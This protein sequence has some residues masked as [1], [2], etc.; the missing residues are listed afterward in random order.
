MDLILFFRSS[1]PS[2]LSFYPSAMLKA[3][4]LLDYRLLAF[5][6]SFI[7]FFALPS[8]SFLFSQENLFD[9][10]VLTPEDGLA[11]LLTTSIYKD[12]QGFMWAGTAYGLNRYDGYNFKLF[13]KEKNALAANADIS[14][15][16][17]DEKGR[18]WLFYRSGLRMLPV[19]QSI[20]A[21]DIFDPRSQRAVPFDSLFSGRAP[22][23]AS[24]I[25][26]PKIIDPKHRLWIHTN[27]GA[28]FLYENGEFK[29]VFQQDGA[30]FQFI[31]ID[32]DE[33][34]WLGGQNHLLHIDSSGNFLERLEL[35][36]QIYGVWTGEG[37]SMWL[38]TIDNNAEQVHI[39]I[40]SQSQNGH[41]TPL[42]FTRNGQAVEI[43]AYKPF[44]HLSQKRYWLALVGE[45][46]HV[47]NIQGRWLY[48]Y[49]PI[50]GRRPD[51]EPFTFFEDLDRLWLASSTGILNISAI[52]NPFQ[53]IHKKNNMFT[54]CRSIT[55]DENGNI[56][57]LNS[58]I[59]QWNVQNQKSRELP[60]SKGAAYCLIYE[61]SMVWAGI[62]NSS[63]IAFQL[64]LRTNE[65][66][67]YYSFKHENL[68]IYT[69]TKTE[70]PGRY[71]A[72]LSKGIAYLDIRKKKLLP[73]NGYDLGDNENRLLEQ[74]EVNFIHKNR[75]GYWLATNNGIF[76]LQE[77]KG[78]IQHFDKSKDD[79]PF[80]YI[81]HI[82]EDEEGFFWLATKGGGVIQ[83]HHGLLEEAEP[84]GKA[85][86]NSYRQ[87]TTEDGLANNFTYA[88]YEDDFGKLWIPS[89]K[90]L[91][92]VDKE[93]F[94]VRT[95]T[96]DDGL[97]HNEFNFTSH[98]QS[99]D[100]TL[101]F[102]GLDG[103]ISFHPKTFANKNAN[104]T[105]MAIIGYFVL[106]EGT[107]KMVDK[108][109]LLQEGN[110]LTIH[111]NDKFIELYFT[112]LDFDD[113][114]KHQYAYQ[115]GGYSSS[116]HYPNENFIRITNLPYGKYTL[117]IKGQNSSH[118]WSQ[119]E[120]M[121]AIHVV[122]PFYLQ[123]WFITLLCF[124]GG[125]SML[126]AVLLRIKK[127]ESGKKILEA[128]V[129]KRTRQLEEKT[130]Q[131]ET[132]N[133]QIAADKQVI[134]AQAESLQA[135]DKAKT[136]FFSNITHEFRTPLTL[137]IGPLEQVI[138][139]QS[140]PTIFRRR[141]HG[142]LGNARHLL[143]LINQLLDISKIESGQMQIEAT[144]GDLVA[145]T[146][147][148]VK[149]F[150]PLA[151][152]KDLRLSFVTHMN[153]W[154]TQFDKEK[155]D[156]IVYN[157]LSNAIKFT[158][159]ANAIQV[160]LVNK[161]HNGSEFIQLDVKDTGMGIEKKQIGY[162]FDR[163]YQTDS[164][165]THTQG[166]TGIGLA[167]VKELVEMQGGEVR[168][169]SELGKGTT[170]EVL[171][172]VLA[173]PH[174]AE[175]LIR[176]NLEISSLAVS[177]L[178]EKKE[179]TSWPPVAPSRK[180]KLELLIIEDNDE[181]RE[182]IHY[183]IDASK[184]NITEAGDGAEGL[185]KAQTLIPDL[186]ISDV[187]MPKKNGFEVT[188]AIRSHINTSHIPLILLTARASL[189]SRLEG[190]QRGAD[191]YLTKPFSPQELA[192][193]VEK[194]IEI[195]QLLQQRYSGGLSLTKD[196]AYQQ[197]D[198][199]IIRLREYILEHIDETNLNGDRIGRHLGMSRTHL[200]RKLKALTGQP[201]TDF[202]RSIRLQKALEMI[203]R[204]QENVSEVAY[205]TGFS[206]VSH[207]SRSFKK[208]FGKNPSEF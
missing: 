80:N 48:T 102:G 81:R 145:Y 106:E 197:E 26:L 155:W 58:R 169:A 18:L 11:N 127:L 206:S 187:M 34:I 150:A 49:D 24:E 134:I 133:R 198:E 59:Y 104:A 76:L 111:P 31:T 39:N 157:L 77:H 128:E 6:F 61:D 65:K 3:E 177:A 167:L 17:E 14:Q 176:D 152:E 69:V 112:L 123:W 208:A 173:A 105:P 132:Q 51:I 139:E 110:G 204:G 67:E 46:L 202:V 33:N 98:Y 180:G 92:Q 7:L 137:I 57:F 170:F 192:M 23:R 131:L 199:F 163:F 4:R 22:F 149:R 100:G 168:V 82:Y 54:D 136:R 19:P 52:P 107:N 165:S 124:L 158:P 95:F 56:Y 96:T 196:T 148:L 1:F 10:Q 159:R 36:E 97:P 183:C 35:P 5:F 129:Q 66:T 151:I 200:H 141:L 99:K 144:Q 72:G 190:L 164:S 188:H 93:S 53:L 143:V 20:D 38:A 32:D 63:P 25:Y 13:T 84:A 162:V 8:P 85:Y 15:V 147:E 201:I 40:W 172:P 191:A 121:V 119:Q 205:Q 126:T 30:F 109:K 101:Y 146:Q 70:T 195:R 88:V 9:V 91:M 75:L 79:L 28:L 21:L 94:Q 83:W 89:D 47:F 156:K 90:G 138:S 44:L 12:K 74:S 50:S 71:L 108:T 174:R 78:V 194:L 62:Y 118:G 43:E 178:L 207:F 171:L 64:D 140:L 161:Q 103:L 86:K 16:R 41:L 37:Q 68:Q 153:H 117:R 203:R 60:N 154:E 160:S 122:K 114:E 29:K 115:I 42:K 185:E 27:K 184:Y 113:T 186:I 166:G 120:L 193:R 116:W 45:Q 189:E 179:P 142:V 73:Y 125:C 175:L 181:V 130:F 55:E 2:T 87:F 182:Y 135:L